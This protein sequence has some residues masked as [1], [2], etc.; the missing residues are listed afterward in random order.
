MP[1]VQ[2]SRGERTA[3][4]IVA[5]LMARFTMLPELLDFFQYDAKKLLE[6]IDR[7]GGMSVEIPPRHVVGRMA[8]DIDIY[9]ALSSTPTPEKIKYL[10]EKHGLTEQRVGQIRS[11]T[12][13]TLA[14]LDQR[15]GF[16]S[17]IIRTGV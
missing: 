12:A 14:T 5:L 6:F 9:R 15:S 10:A 16:D 2:L 17:S 7:F 1:D 11:E 3:M 13:E 4:W 8:R